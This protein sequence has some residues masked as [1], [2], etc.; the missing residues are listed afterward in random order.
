MSHGKIDQVP[1]MDE[2]KHISFFELSISLK[3]KKSGSGALSGKM[4]LVR[5][6]KSK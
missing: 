6:I 5:I 3:I 1:F 4:F 2:I